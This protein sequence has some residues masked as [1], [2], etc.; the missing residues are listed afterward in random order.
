MVETRALLHALALSSAD[1]GQLLT[2]MN[3][4]LVGDVGNDRFVTLFLA[5]LDPQGRRL[6][7]SNAGHWPGFVLDGDGRVKAEMHSTSM[8]LGLDAET[9]YATGAEI[10][11]AEGDLF[12]VITDGILE[13]YGPEAGLFGMDRALDFMRAHRDA[14]PEEMIEALFDEATR[15]AYGRQTDDMSAL[16]MKVCAA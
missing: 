12:F 7:C 13:S 15:F 8:P 11:L 16:V 10:P 2:R 9:G 4:R 1:P 14:P 3:H 6:V 5:R